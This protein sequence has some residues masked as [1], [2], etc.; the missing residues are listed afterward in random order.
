VIVGR[1]RPDFGQ[2]AFGHQALGTHC[3]PERATDGTGLGPSIEYR[4]HHLD[5]ARAGVTVLA[6]VTVET[7]RAVIAAFGQFFFLEK[8]HWKD[9]G[10]PAVATPERQ[11]AISYIVKP[12]YRATLPATILV[13]QPTSVSRIAIGRQR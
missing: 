7:Q 10:M 6:E 9:C 3:V 11:G 12:G 13:V 8:V 2:C 1:R 4:T 5:L